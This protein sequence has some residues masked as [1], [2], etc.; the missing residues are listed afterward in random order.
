MARNALRLQSFSGNK[1]PSVPFHRGMKSCLLLLPF[2]S[3]S[4]QTVSSGLVV[5]FGVAVPAKMYGISFGSLL[6]HRQSASDSAG[7]SFFARLWRHSA[8]DVR[9]C[10]SSMMKTVSEEAPMSPGCLYL[11]EA[12]CFLAGRNRFKS[13]AK[14]FRSVELRLCVS[15]LASSRLWFDST[16]QRAANL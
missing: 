1:V 2:N 16:I 13:C 6:V 4:R 15:S 7:A 10:T 11:P 8:G 14:S 12:V 9:F 3:C 5:V